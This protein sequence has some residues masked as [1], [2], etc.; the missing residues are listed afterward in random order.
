MRTFLDEDNVDY[1]YSRRRSMD[2][3]SVPASQA[4]EDSDRELSFE[5]L[6]NCADEQSKH[7]VAE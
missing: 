3:L 6:E 2:D 5:Y 4:E 7:D 1:F